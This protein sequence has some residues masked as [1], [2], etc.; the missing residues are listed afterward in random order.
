MNPDMLYW[1]G[2]RVR[3]GSGIS[4]EPKR[5]FG[6]GNAARIIKVGQKIVAKLHARRVVLHKDALIGGMRIKCSCTIS[7]HHR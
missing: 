3:C 1:I 6:R 7:I 2:F 5:Y 4:D